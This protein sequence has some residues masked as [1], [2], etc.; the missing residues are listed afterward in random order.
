MNHK[1]T[2]TIETNRLLLRKYE[3][4][5]A[6][7]MYRNWVTDTEVSRFC[8]WEP[9]KD[10]EETKSLLQGWINDYANRE[11]YHWVIIL[12]EISEAIGYIYLN[13]I[14][15]NEKSA[16]IHYLVSRKFWNQG[17][18]TEACR[19]VLAFLF[20]EIGIIKIQTHH[21]K[22]NPASGKVMQ[23]SGMRYTGTKY[24]TVPDCEQI[25]GEYCYYEMTVDDWKRNAGDCPRTQSL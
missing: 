7:A 13:E 17:I 12:K 22:D 11:Y 9:H 23:K 10:I 15:N 4:T 8:G 20:M 18:M 16:S 1:G 2:Q 21:H 25:S 3:I 5:D 14:N 24:R 6:E 19:A